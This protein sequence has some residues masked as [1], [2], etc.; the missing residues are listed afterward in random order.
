M[1]L[2]LHCRVRP[3]AVQLLQV[4]DT[5]LGTVTVRVGRATHRFET[6]IILKVLQFHVVIGAFQHRIPIF[7]GAEGNLM[8]L[9]I[10]EGVAGNNI[11]GKTF[12]GTS[13][14]PSACILPATAG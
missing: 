5:T 6:A 4:V 1:Q 7:P 11:E 9:V 10:L 2:P 12:P 3:A 14:I 13:P 8:T